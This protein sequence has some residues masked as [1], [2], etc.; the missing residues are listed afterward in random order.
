MYLGKKKT[1]KK[2]QISRKKDKV[3]GIQKFGVKKKN[4]ERNK[5]INK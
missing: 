5:K 2:K 4:T 1:K 3:E